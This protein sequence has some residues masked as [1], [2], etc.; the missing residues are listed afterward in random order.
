[1]ICASSKYRCFSFAAIVA[2]PSLGL[3]PARFAPSPH[4]ALPPPPRRR[5][6]LDADDLPPPGPLA[7]ARRPLELG[8]GFAIAT[9]RI[10]RIVVVVVARR[11]STSRA[12]RRSAAAD[13]TTR[14]SEK[15]A[16][17]RFSF[18]NVVCRPF[19]TRRVRAG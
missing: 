16:R 15:R 7:D 2:P 10:A 3:F 18:A 6:T 17:P 12:T 8:S 14:K 9:H 19:A 4:A 1:M 11:A 5:G 13:A